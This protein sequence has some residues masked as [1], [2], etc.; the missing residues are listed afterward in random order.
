MLSLPRAFPL[1]PEDLRFKHELCPLTLT[2]NSV[3]I[4]VRSESEAAYSP[5]FMEMLL[6]S[7]VSSC[8]L[9]D[10]S[11]PGTVSHQ[12]L[13]GNPPNSQPKLNRSSVYSAPEIFCI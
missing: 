8:L 13:W 9:R 12:D 2:E 4:G 1:E 11:I 7:T 10:P 6:A 5:F 3:A